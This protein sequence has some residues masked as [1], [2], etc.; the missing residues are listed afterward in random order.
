M[1]KLVSEI[2]NVGI[3]GIF[4]KYGII[5]NI[6]IIEIHRAVETSLADHKQAVKMRKREQQ[7]RDRV[8]V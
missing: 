3:Y 5:F 1:V 8:C 7:V 2:K 6:H 4:V